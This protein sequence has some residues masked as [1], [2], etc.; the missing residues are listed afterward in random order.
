MAALEIVSAVLVLAGVWLVGVLDIRGQ[1]L[2]AAAQMGWAVFAALGGHWW[3]LAQS[4]I[5]FALTLRAI[6]YWRRARLAA[7]G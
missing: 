5:L 1:Y 2:L 6:R 4:V 3:L 7:L